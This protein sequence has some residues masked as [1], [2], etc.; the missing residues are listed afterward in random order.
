MILHMIRYTLEKQAPENIGR[1]LATIWK[2]SFWHSSSN[3]ETDLATAD[4]QPIQKQTNTVERLPKE[5]KVLHDTAI[6]SERKSSAV[7]TDSH[8]FINNEWIQVN[9]ENLIREKS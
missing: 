9:C 5:A 8:F 6:C 3:I 4:D 7:L 1:E 2:I